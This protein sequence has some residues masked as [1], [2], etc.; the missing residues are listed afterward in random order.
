MPALRS[1]A[2]V[3]ST[4]AIVASF[5]AKIKASLP[6]LKDRLSSVAQRLDDYMT[7]DI[8]KYL[9]S[10]NYISFKPVASVNDCMIY[11]TKSVTVMIDNA[12]VYEGHS[13]GGQLWRYEPSGQKNK[14]VSA[15]RDIDNMVKAAIKCIDVIDKHAMPK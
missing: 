14:C 15:Y 2:M 4:S 10:R 3:P 12:D 6:P 7:N 11:M 13:F 9:R 5:K 8:F 1:D